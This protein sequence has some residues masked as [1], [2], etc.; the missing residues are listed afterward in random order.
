LPHSPLTSL[1][2]AFEI[3]NQTQ[4][5]YTV[6]AMFAPRSSLRNALA[7]IAP[8]CLLWLFLSCVLAC[9]HP[10]EESSTADADSACRLQ[11]D[12]DCLI[13]T[14]TAIALPERFFF[15]PDGNSEANFAAAAHLIEIAPRRSTQRLI[16]RSSLSP[17]FARL[18]TLRI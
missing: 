2:Q 10:L 6:E 13:T 5:A 12:E 3:G 18:F 9:A 8:V 14:P 7:F 16:F 11:A 4:V 15:S 17:P 1:E